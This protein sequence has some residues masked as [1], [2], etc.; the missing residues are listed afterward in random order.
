MDYDYNTHTVNQI[1]VADGGGDFD[2]HDH[3]ND[4]I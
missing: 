3:G 1:G 2:G 4:P